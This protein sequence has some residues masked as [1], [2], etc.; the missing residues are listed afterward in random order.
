[1]SALK[2][3]LNEEQIFRDEAVFNPYGNSGEVTVYPETEE[4]ISA[5]LKYA[6]SNKLT[7]N[8][9]GGGTKR[10]FGGLMEKSG[11]LLSLERYKGIVEHTPGDMTVTVK[12]GTPF[13]DIQ[14]YLAKYNQKI[15]L[16]PFWPQ[17]ATIGGIIAANESGP[18]RLGYGSARDAVIGLRTV[19]PDGKVIRSGGKVVKNVAGYDMNKLFIGSMGTLG[20]VSEIT[21]KLRP[22]PKCESLVL[23][24]F[25]QGKMEKIKV[26]AV[27]ILDSMIEPVTMELLNP[28]LANKLAG[29]N[30]YT[31]ALTFEDVESSVRY[32]EEF[33]KNILPADADLRIHSKEESESF[34]SE[35]YQ[36]IPNTAAKE[37]PAETEASLKIGSVNMSILNV[38]KEAELLIDLLNV[39]IE[40]HG[41]LGHG[42][43]QVTIR[44]AAEDVADAAA[45]V[46]QIAESTGG[47]AIVKHMTFEMR[48]EI[49]VWGENPSYFFLLQGIKTKIDPLKTL[50]PKRFVGGI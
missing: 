2:K 5:V 7:I 16:D 14:D 19:Y 15:S 24:S 26:L 20:V 22:L 40:S 25:P 44:G 28:A 42:L 29:I 27:N 43:S 3:L 36:H 35:F 48:K 49:S 33:I 47:Y 6:N 34:W 37:L 39:S 17:M 50:N 12:A 11:I 8:I 13:N 18:K 21:L 38:M 30:S 10:G 9:T 23:V 46:R 32:Q 1:M 41:G 31:L 45:K 4:E